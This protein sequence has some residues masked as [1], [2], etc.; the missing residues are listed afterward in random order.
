ML[1]DDAV[2]RLHVLQRASH[3]ERVEDAESVVTE[4][5]HARAG[6]RHR[7]ELRE[8]LALLSDRHG[9]DRLDVDVAGGLAE[10]ELLLDDTGRVGDGRGVRH[11]EHGRVPA[12]RSGARPRK[13]R[14]GCLIAGLPQMRVQ[15]NEPRQ[16]DEPVGVDHG[17]TRARE[18]GADLAD[19]AVRDEQVRGIPAAQAG[20]LDQVRH[21]A[22]SCV[23]VSRCSSRSPA[24]SR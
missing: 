9:A 13:D 4:D 14:L 19:H 10:S 7:S 3:D 22:S 23:V 15:V 12:R 2:E 5:A 24:S 1:R 17:R 16:G 21:R 20:S 6:R 18:A 11:R 8:A